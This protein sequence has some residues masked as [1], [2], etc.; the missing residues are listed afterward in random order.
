M[1]LV[2]SLPGPLTTT[3]TTKPEQKLA[4]N[5]D[6]ETLNTHKGGEMVPAVSEDDNLQQGALA[7][8]HR[9][10]L[11]V[12]LLFFL[13]LLYLLRFFAFFFSSPSCLRKLWL[14]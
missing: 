14:P 13:P 6:N 1:I 3:T 12:L 8:R 7:C 9:N 10:L 5:T 4:T 2:A 11:L